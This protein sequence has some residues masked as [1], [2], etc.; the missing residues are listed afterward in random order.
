M[1]GSEE[2]SVRVIWPFYSTRTP[3]SGFGRF[4]FKN[5]LPTNKNVVLCADYDGPNAPTHKAL[6][7]DKAF[8]ESKGYDVSILWPATMG[9]QKVDFN[10]VLKKEGPAVIKQMVEKQ[11][12]YKY[13]PLAQQYSERAKEA[14]TTFKAEQSLSQDQ[15]K[16]RIK[17][18]QLSL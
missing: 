11:L 4:V 6:L 5:A 8:L 2:G 17:G 16:T 13:E 9:E 1:S 18:P 3:L 14:L 12:D 7:A 15:E 10:D